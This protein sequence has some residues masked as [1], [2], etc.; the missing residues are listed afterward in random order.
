[1]TVALATA[2]AESRNTHDAERRQDQRRPEAIFSASGT[3]RFSP[4]AF[5]QGAPAL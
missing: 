2:F 4:K 3:T 1:M 5:L